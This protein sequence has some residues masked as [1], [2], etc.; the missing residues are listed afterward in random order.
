VSTDYRVDHR[1]E[2]PFRADAVD[3]RLQPG[4]HRREQ[5]ALLGLDAI[6]D[7]LQLALQGVLLGLQG[8]LAAVFAEADSMAADC[9]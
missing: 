4:L 3:D 5:L 1:R 9:R 6:P 2:I 7:L 8:L